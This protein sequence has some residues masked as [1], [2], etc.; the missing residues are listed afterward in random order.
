MDQDKLRE[1]AI[2]LLPGS[3]TVVGIFEN[4]VVPK[5]QDFQETASAIG[6]TQASFV[7]MRQILLAQS[8]ERDTA[9]WI[10]PKD[11]GNFLRFQII[12]GAIAKGVERIDLT[13]REEGNTEEAHRRDGINAAPIRCIERRRDNR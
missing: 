13:S 8:E 4:L 1:A 7:L 9:F 5:D 11:D 6:T 2:V 10:A 3:S 12:E